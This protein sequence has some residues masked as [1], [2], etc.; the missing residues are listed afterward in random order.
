MSLSLKFFNFGQGFYSRLLL[1][2]L[3]PSGWPCT[4]LAA[5]TKNALFVLDAT[6]L[7]NPPTTVPVT[8]SLSQR[9]TASAWAAD[10]SCLYVAGSND[11]SKFS[12]T[13]YLYSS[14]IPLSRPS[15]SLITKD[16]GDTLI[17]TSG[18]EIALLQ[19]TTGKELSKLDLQD[20]DATLLS[21]SQDETLIAVCLASGEVQVHNLS[22][23]TSPVVLRG[24]N[25]IGEEAG[26]RAR[27]NGEVTA[28]AFHAH[29]PTQLLL[30][31]GPRLL[32][33]DTVQPAR[34]AKVFLLNKLEGKLVSIACSPFSKT[35]IA[36]AS[37][38]GKIWLVDIAKDSG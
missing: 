5:C 36:V 37:S 16:N 20:Q 28:L 38:T 17:Y 8:T 35:L 33:Y 22:S 3:Y 25:G 2:P 30:A 31:L 26:R 12:P 9:P 1:V 10:N 14:T 24:I 15:T 19:S 23:G 6:T 13:G 34:P 7:K 27:Y 11:I 29:S 21:L 32:V 18:N 4:M